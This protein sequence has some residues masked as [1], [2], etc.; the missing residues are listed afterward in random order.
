MIVSLIVNICVSKSDLLQESKA[1]NVLVI[2]TGQVPDTTSSYVK[3]T[4]SFPRIK[5]PPKSMNSNSEISTGV[6]LTT[7]SVME[8]G[9]QPS[10]V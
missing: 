5:E 2:I 7:K 8:E 1:V 6:V 3:D 9:L 10:I 4:K